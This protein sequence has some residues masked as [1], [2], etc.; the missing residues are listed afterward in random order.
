SWLAV[1]SPLSLG[2]SE[3]SRIDPQTHPQNLMLKKLLLVP[4]LALSLGACATFDQNSAQALITLGVANAI[5]FGV[6]KDKQVEVARQIF[7]AGD[8]YNSI[9][10]SNG[11]PE[12]AQFSALLNKYL[13]ASNVKELSVTELVAVYSVYYPD[14]KDKAPKDQLAALA[15]F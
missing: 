12:P 15:G 11:L 1:F 6:P 5:Q 9:A 8:L 13:P 3:C 7:A 2:L 4:I 14:Y 10:G